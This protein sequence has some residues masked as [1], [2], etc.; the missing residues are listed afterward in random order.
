LVGISPFSD[1]S[2]QRIGFVG[3]G[4]EYALLHLALACKKHFNRNI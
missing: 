3:H 1:V 2:G 4:C